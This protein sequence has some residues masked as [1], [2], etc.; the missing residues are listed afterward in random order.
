MGTL[1]FPFSWASNFSYLLS[2]I[3]CHAFPLPYS[4]SLSY[5]N[6]LLHICISCGVKGVPHPTPA[7]QDSKHSKE[8]PEEEEEGEREGV[9]PTGQEAAGDGH[10]AEATGQLGEE[11]ATATGQLG[12]TGSTATATGQ[13]AELK[14]A[15]TSIKTGIGILVDLLPDTLEGKPFPQSVL[16]AQSL[17]E[18]SKAAE[19]C[20]KWK[21]QVHGNQAVK[22]E[23]RGLS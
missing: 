10:A 11:H 3:F 8:L 6:F 2:G 5:S 1:L 15:V 21:M 23:D 19:L 13:L 4:L 14:Q 9:P 18:L 20:Y 7:L 17:E 22:I 16:D 12:E